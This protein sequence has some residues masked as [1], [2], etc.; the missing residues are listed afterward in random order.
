MF[1]GKH[2]QHAF[3]P[4]DEVYNE[5]VKQIQSEM[6]QLKHRHLELISL[7]QDVE[8]NVQIVK[9]AKEERVRELRNAIELMITRLDSQLK[10]KLVTLMGQR[11]EL[12]QEIELLEALLQGVQTELDTVSRAEII[13]R[14]PEI[15][16]LFAEVH[17]K[18]TTTFA[19]TPVPADFIRCV[20]CLDSSYV[21][22]SASALRLCFLL[23]TI[24][25][26]RCVCVKQITVR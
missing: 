13:N 4:L 7:F 25:S 20:S 16:A 1:D 3:R 19:T 26:N 21:R 2:A 23:H 10:S 12:F 18:P 8:K 14:Y 11:S 9:Q 24:V 22:F 15:L 5:H 6:D 17:R